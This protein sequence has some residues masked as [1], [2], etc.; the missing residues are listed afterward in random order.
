MDNTIMIYWLMGV[1]MVSIGI[2]LF[3]IARYLLV[4]EDK[5]KQIAGYIKY[6]GIIWIVIGAIIFLGVII[7]LLLNPSIKP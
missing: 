2:S 3:Y 7:L 6:I 4:P 1:V 5:K